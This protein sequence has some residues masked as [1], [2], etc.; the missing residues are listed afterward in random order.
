MYEHMHVPP[1]LHASLCE[2]PTH[3]LDCVSSLPN[4]LRISCQRCHLKSDVIT[5]LCDN[6][7]QA[8][9]AVVSIFLKRPLRFLEHL[10]LHFSAPFHVGPLP[11]N[12]LTFYTLP[13]TIIKNRSRME[14]IRLKA[15]RFLLTH[16]SGPRVYN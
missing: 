2:V 15:F 1:Q 7:A 5:E 4:K 12:T 16:L 11:R 8:A 14:G 9:A 10:L 6:L 3:L 13:Y